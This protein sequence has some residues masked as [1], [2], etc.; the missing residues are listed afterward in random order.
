MIGCPS[1]SNRIALHS[2]CTH[3]FPRSSDKRNGVTVNDG[4]SVV[5]AD[6]ILYAVN[7]CVY[8]ADALALVV[9]VTRVRTI[10]A[11][12]IFRNDTPRACE[13]SSRRVH[14]VGGID[15]N[16]GMM[17]SPDMTHIR[18]TAVFI[19]THKRVC[20]TTTC[21]ARVHHLYQG[22]KG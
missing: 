20:G 8:P 11:E 22:D 4:N 18:R 7:T 15:A 2:A 6:L 10:G 1:R 9:C 17:I 16:E 13:C 12:V 21:G 3:G 14:D 19:T 5:D